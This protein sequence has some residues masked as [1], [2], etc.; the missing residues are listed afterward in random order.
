MVGICERRSKLLFEKLHLT[1][2]P[3][4]LHVEK[5]TTHMLFTIKRKYKLIPSLV[6]SGNMVLSIT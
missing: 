5:Y 3:S 2:D 6:K 1:L 4:Y